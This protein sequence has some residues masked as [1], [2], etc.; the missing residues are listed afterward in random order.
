MKEKTY[1]ARTEA[2]TF[3]RDEDPAHKPAAGRCAAIPCSPRQFR[4]QVDVEVIS[5]PDQGADSR[6][7]AAMIRSR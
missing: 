3:P 7:W 6:R 1:A 5:A 2:T 4:R